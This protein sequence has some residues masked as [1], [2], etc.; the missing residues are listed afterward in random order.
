MTGGV[1]AQSNLGLPLRG[2][3]VS[4]RTLATNR[5]I[6]V[7]WG[8]NPPLVNDG[9]GAIF[10]IFAKPPILRKRAVLAFE[11]GTNSFARTPGPA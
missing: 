10:A 7:I 2:P 9:K 8:P 4:I 1:L 6:P 5:V 3:V 11:L